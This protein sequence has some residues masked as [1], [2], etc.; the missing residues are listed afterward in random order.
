MA[1][2][3]VLALDEG[4]SSARAVLV[5]TNGQI[6]SESSAEITASYPRPSWVELDPTMLWDAART[7]MDRAMAKAGATSADIAAVGITTHR[8]SCLIWNRETGLPIYNAIMWMSKQ[9]DDIVSQWSL[10]GMDDDIRR[11]TGVRNDSYFSAGKLAWILDQVPG[12]R[13][14]AEAGKL[15]A[16]TVDTWLL[17]NLTGGQSHATDPSSAS[18]TAM[19]NIREL[20]WDE[21]LCARYGIP[22]KL[23][24]EV[25]PSNSLFGHVESSLLS[26]TGSSA[27]PITAI[28]ADQQAGLFGQACFELGSAKNTYGTAG[29]L[30]VNV[31]EQP[32]IIPGMSSSIAWQVTDKAVYEVEGVVFHCGQTLQWLRDKLHIID[33]VAHSA[34]AAAALSDNGGVYF[35][36]AFAG[37]CDP[38]WDRDVRAAIIGLTLD[39]GA[40]H[41]VRAGLEA[42]AYQTRDNVLALERGGLPIP[43][44]RV[45]GG[46][47]SNDFLCQFQADLLGIPVERP[48]ELERT[49]LG[50]AQLAGIGVGMWSGQSDLSDAWRAERIFEPKISLDHRE[51]LYSGWQDAV[52]AARSIAPAR[53]SRVTKLVTAV[54]LAAASPAA[55][56]ITAVATELVAHR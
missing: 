38:Y 34:N 39:T 14:D 48:R 17:W 29:V 4:S 40:E 28:L 51:E 55:V 27:I 6:V 45:D 13:M 25:L 30:T 52:A 53:I 12:A 9:T 41:I 3:Y 1:G 18:R 37:L 36:P 43:S 46:A 19:Y 23:L 54:P 10:D 49:A 21:D 22:M 7:S 26:G 5:D 16:G 24:P 50:V 47:I 32:R 15:A 35:V 11:L 20:R 8:E 42:M 2:K 31:G 33:S 56:P 44:L